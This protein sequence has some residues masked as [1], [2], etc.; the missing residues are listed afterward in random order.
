MENVFEKNIN[1]PERF[2]HDKPPGLGVQNEHTRKSS[3]QSTRMKKKNVCLIHCRADIVEAFRQQV[4]N[5]INLQP[6]PGESIYD[7]SAALEGERILP[8]LIFQ[9]ENLS[10]R[11]L[12]SGLD[13]YDCPKIFWGLDTHLNA[14]WHSAYARLFDITC[15]TQKRIIP[16]LQM[17]GARDVR[18][19][20]WY[21]PSGEW[22]PWSKRT[23]KI[24][25]VGRITPERPARQWLAGMLR[26]RFKDAIPLLADGLPFAEML[27][28]YR[29]SMLAPNEAIFNEINLRLFEGASCG[30]LVLNPDT[31]QELEGL[32]DPGKEVEIY[33]TILDLGELIDRHLRNQRRAQIMG[34]A[35]FERTHSEHLVEHRVKRILSFA[36][37][38]CS[39][40]A[41]GKKNE[42]WFWLSA[43]FLWEAGLISVPLKTILEQISRLEQ[44]ADVVT[45][46]LRS[47]VHKESTSSSLVML[48]S[49]LTSRQFEDSLDVNLAGS[50]LALSAGKEA[51]LWDCAKAF[52]YRHLQSSGSRVPEPPQDNLHLHMLWARELGKCGRALRVGFRFDSERHLPASATECLATILAEDSENL[53]ALKLMEALTRNVRGLEQGRVGYLS[54]LTLHEREDW[55]MGLELALANLR[56]FRLNEGLEEMTTAKALAE[57]QGQSSHFKRMF[58]ARDQLGRL[59]TLLDIV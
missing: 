38:A 46:I 28:L 33:D 22:V 14:H 39:H 13:A 19:L 21:A 30:C 12:V 8:D 29:K 26:S 24:S 31:G 25:F 44:D 58:K 36:A 47:Q 51:S 34:R 42:K 45:A 3:L 52:W 59:N 37:D 35:A 6:E 10:Q 27:A 57:A 9:Q 23:H 11:V 50:M 15:S 16:D 17:R 40:A 41:T 18:W 2:E 1:S 7:V 5:V 4:D 54:I 20:P 56:A 32:Y 55:R 43:F 53:E 49:L 48:Q